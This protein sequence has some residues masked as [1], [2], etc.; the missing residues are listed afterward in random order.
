MILLTTSR[1]PTGR[2]RT[3]CRDLFNSIPDVVRVNRGKMS[4][5][6][7]AEKAIELDADRIVVVDRWHGGP[8]KVSIFSLSSTGL[9]FVPPMLLISGIRLRR[10][11]KEGTKR[12]RSS[13]ITI[14]PEASPELEIV[15]RHLSQ[16]FNLP[17]VSLDGACKNHR[18]SMHFSF[19]SSGRLQ[20]TF[21]LL[22]RMV[23]I[24]PR[25]TMSKLVWEVP[26]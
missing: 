9:K 22:Q 25:L 17:I 24:G 7:V 1:R 23:E 12:V 21:L 13:V 4:R 14:E 2:I 11:L 6:G 10:E 5:D 20:I 18:V 3:F 19:D 8:G 26:S 16:F 15:A